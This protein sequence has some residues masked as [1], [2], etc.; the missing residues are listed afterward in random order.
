MKT[1][2][3]AWI[4]LASGLLSACS[5]A[6]RLETD[7]DAT[8]KLY[9][10]HNETVFSPADWVSFRQ[11]V[12]VTLLRRGPDGPEGW[13]VDEWSLSEDGHTSTYH[14]RENA[15]WHDGV[16]VT[17]DD[18]EYSLDL[19]YNPPVRAAGRR[20]FD[21][22]VLDDKTFRIRYDD[23][24]TRRSFEYDVICFPKH[25]LEVLDREGFWYWDF[26]KRPIGNGP[27]RYV[28]HI[29]EVMTK[30]AADPQYF[31]PGPAV[32]TV[33]IR[34]GGVVMMEL[35]AGNV[36]VHVWASADELPKF[37]HN[38]RLD[39]ALYGGSVSILYWNHR[40]PFLREAEARRALTMAIDRVSMLEAR[41]LDEA[42]P[43][44]D[45]PI[46][47]L[48]RSPPSAPIPFD[49]GQATRI[50]GELGWADSDGDGV[51]E[52]DGS[53]FRFEFLVW[54]KNQEHEA[55]FIQE[56]LRRI[57]VA[58]EINTRIRTAVEDHLRTG[59]FDAAF[60]LGRDWQWLTLGES[61]E[62]EDPSRPSLI[63]Y[64]HADLYEAVFASLYDFADDADARFDERLWEIFQR[65]V[66]V[67]V[68]G[69]SA[70]AV[71]FDRRLHGLKP[72]RG[73]PF[74]DQVRIEEEIR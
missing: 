21:L 40:R 62:F 22:Q 74:M 28:H 55:V 6:D 34:Y 31:L 54:N 3:S 8:L 45:A 59:D 61:I 56:S 48:Y 66:P 51:L 30:L 15:F 57:G 16:P 44:L 46:D 72:F 71:V 11:L 65:D 12:F 33:M 53:D 18:I 70:T 67:T 27:F 63:G 64:D 32:D 13:L 10:P 42:L 14:L 73:F 17:T 41:D 50:L 52:R 68:L 9:Y 29:P 1:A 43:V 37:R 26:W 25:Q 39:H 35:L 5:P 20:R 7:R 36:D 23:V 47:F 60:H 24:R 4:L 2:R 38:P 19:I 49:P 69:P 58:V